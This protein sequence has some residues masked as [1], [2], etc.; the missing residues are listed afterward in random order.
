MKAKTRL[1]P[2]LACCV[3]G[4][5]GLLSAGWPRPAHG[6]ITRPVQTL[7]Q[8]CGWS[9]YVTEVRVEK[10]SK[11]KGIIVYRKVRD[12]K[13]K[14]PRDTIRHVFDLKNTP[15]HQG[16]GDVPVR[17][18]EVD[19]KYAVG[20]AEVGKTAVVVALKYDP[21]G[22]FGHTYID[23]L[24]Y[25]TMC[26]QRDWDLFYAIYSDPALLS[27]WHCGS[28]AQLV[29]AVEKMLAGKEAVLPVMVEGTRQ[30][31]RLGRA[32]IKGLK[33][34]LNIHDYNPQRDLVSSW[35]DKEMVPALIKSLQDSNRDTR[36]KA[37]RE[38]GL[39]GPDARD[40]VPG[41]VAVVQGKDDEL[42][43]AAL[44]ALE[45]IG[46]EARAAL[47]AFRAALKEG[48]PPVR[49]SAV[50][51]LGKLGAAARPALPELAP[52]LARSEG[53]ARVET[54]EAVARI[55]PENKEAVATLAALLKDPNGET[56]IK[57]VEV[58]A[59]LG[60]RARSSEA[61]L[62]EILKE[63]DTS[64][65]IR[66][67]ELLAPGG[68]A[69]PQVLTATA[70]LV[71]DRTTAK[72][73]RL[74]A[75]T[76]LSELGA[77]AHPAVPALVNTLKDP[78]RDIRIKTAE[79]LAAVGPA[80]RTAIPALAEAVRNESSGTVRM[81]AADALAALGPDARSAKAALEA[82]LGDPRMAQRP[83]VLA[84]IKEVLGKLR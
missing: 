16:S 45:Q 79:V 55:D 41:L 67:V 81:R 14:Y 12:L 42:R 80:A 46:A 20:W 65:R 13:G 61:A 8:L 38:L 10:V 73:I 60:A 40:A 49:Q 74:R 9:T 32:K 24:W 28:P 44:M 63:P 54:A 68:L 75:A 69:R 23:G 57:A 70:S 62:A 84:K 2:Y 34:G 83:E 22:D 66:A 58:L 43:L 51:A 33:V 71:E 77:A 25:A 18:D 4:G 56:R 17:P 53:I 31:L 7:G 21:Y 47:P 52:L 50:R 64:L 35:V 76:V 48:N 5:I 59:H 39:I 78:D 27:R 3:L 30:E 36:A 11:E 29:P 19:W 15:Q 1:S 72:E 82:A 37:V 6:Y 26:P